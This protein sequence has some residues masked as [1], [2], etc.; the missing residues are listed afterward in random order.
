MAET[1]VRKIPLKKITSIEEYEKNNK[2]LQY[3]LE[4]HSWFTSHDSDESRLKDINHQLD[5]YREKLVQ[6]PKDS[7]EQKDI[8][9]SLHA[10]KVKYLRIK[11]G[12]YDSV[13]RN[14]IKAEMIML[15]EYET[16]LNKIPF[17]KVLAGLLTGNKEAKEY[18]RKKLTFLFNN[19]YGMVE[20]PQDLHLEPHA[21]FDFVKEYTDSFVD[22]NTI[23]FIK[24]QEEKGLV[25]YTEEP[26]HIQKKVAEIIQRGEQAI[27]NNSSVVLASNYGPTKIEQVRSV[28]ST[29]H[30]NMHINNHKNVEREEKERE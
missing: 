8:Y 16:Q 24:E 1:I 26:G 5:E 29:M 2:A 15:D 30:P 6:A 12:T 10:L 21:I 19:S 22:T 14:N 9:S 27:L 17:G 4:E 28:S 3:Y 25:T 23:D 7:E 20:K 13:L 11:D 18:V